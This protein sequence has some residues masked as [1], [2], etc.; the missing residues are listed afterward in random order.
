M[1]DCCSQFPK[2]LS[3]QM[4]AVFEMLTP[5]V[6]G[7]LMFSPQVVAQDHPNILG[8]PSIII[9]M[10][11]LQALGPGN[12]AAPDRV[13]PS[14]PAFGGVVPPDVGLRGLLAPPATAPRSTLN[15]Q[16]QALFDTSSPLLQPRHTTHRSTRTALTPDTSKG[17]AQGRDPSVTSLPLPHMPTAQD[18]PPVPPQVAAPGGEVSE[19]VVPEAMPESK[20]ELG[21][22]VP[23]PKVITPIPEVQSLA[24]QPQQ[25]PVIAPLM[26]SVQGLVPK[27][28]PKGDLERLMPQVATRS[29]PDRSFSGGRIIF[30]GGSAELP[31]EA[32]AVLQ[33][34]ISRL[35]DDEDNRIQL[36]AYAK[37]TVEMVSQARR[38]SLSRA[39]AVRSY[40]IGEGVRSTRMDVRALGN[41]VEE[42]PA[43][44]VDLILVRR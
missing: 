42:G 36:L 2:A 13:Q 12:G 24:G 22:V 27:V 18:V 3:A 34:V 7:T 20:P 23:V 16:A 19:V 9:D 38:L 44:R 6:V 31:D 40:L 35:L 26:G 1:T 11:V 30:A 29:L 41:N 8:N 21:R 39:L 32:K 14:A 43:D 25:A 17:S 4:L 15:P 33:G 10:G 28:A 5:I 37:G